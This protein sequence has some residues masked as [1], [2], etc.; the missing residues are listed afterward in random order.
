MIY[1]N[2][3]IACLLFYQLYYFSIRIA[4]PAIINVLSKPHQFGHYGNNTLVNGLDYI[5]I[6]HMN[7]VRDIVGVVYT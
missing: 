6:Y 5:I 3:Y 4:V 2:Y 1:S 7:I